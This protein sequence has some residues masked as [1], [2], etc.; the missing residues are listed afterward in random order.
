MNP[1]NS[2]PSIV[3]LSVVILVSALLVAPRFQVTAAPPAPQV[4][5]AGPLPLPVAPVQDQKDIVRGQ[6]RVI[7]DI[8]ESRRVQW[9]K[10]NGN[11]IGWD[12]PVNQMLV[13]TDIIISKDSVYGSD[14]FVPFEAAFFKQ[15]IDGGSSRQFDIAGVVLPYSHTFTTPLYIPFPEGGRL[16]VSREGSAQM[17]LILTGYLEPI[18]TR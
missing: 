1:K 4:E 10:A 15:E 2:F 16:L 13:I 12:L 6:V 14:E 8:Y 9:T 18:L 11:H 7:G 17:S 5:I 3:L